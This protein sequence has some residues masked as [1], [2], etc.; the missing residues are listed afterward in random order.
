MIISHH[1]ELEFGSPKVPVFPEA[2]LLHHLDNMDSKMEAMRSALKRASGAAGE[3]TAWVPSLE[4][5]ILHKARFFEGSTPAVQ[6]GLLAG[7]TPKM[8]EKL[9]SVEEPAAVALTPGDF[10]QK[11]YAALRK[12]GL[13][14][15]A[16]A[17][18]SSE[19]RIE[20]EELLIR[21]P[22]AMTLSLKIPNLQQIAAETAGKPVRIR[23]EADG[24][25]DLP[26]K[27]PPA[28]GLSAPSE[29]EKDS[30]GRAGKKEDKGDGRPARPTLFGEKLQAVLEL[31]K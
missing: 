28:P 23:I 3:F 15:T 18:Q 13:K 24:A 10:K 31:R 8:P 9:E 22:K 2:L 17:V 26:A 30:A 11:L 1:G 19:L 7:S 5:V 25:A 12:A 27:V 14:F 29:A 6:D 20:G 4:R 16:D 21:A